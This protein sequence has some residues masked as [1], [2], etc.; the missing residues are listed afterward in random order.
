MDLALLGGPAGPLPVRVAG[1][2]QLNPQ[3][4]PVGG[5]QLRRVETALRDREF[6]QRGDVGT[7]G[8]LADRLPYLFLAQV[9]AEAIEAG[10]V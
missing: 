8:K 5:D 1:V 3:A 7:S 10:D 6:G 9:A 4:E 2:E